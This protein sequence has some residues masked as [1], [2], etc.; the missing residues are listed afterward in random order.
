MSD[1]IKVKLETDTVEEMIAALRAKA[2]MLES[3]GDPN[4]EPDIEPQHG[5]GGGP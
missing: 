4:G 3:G 2:D 5:G 1:K